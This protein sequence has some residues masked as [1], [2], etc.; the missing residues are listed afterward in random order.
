MSVQLAGT[1]NDVRGDYDLP[2]AACVFLLLAAAGTSF[3]IR[4]KRYSTRLAVAP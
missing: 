4:E 3:A 2:L 1:L